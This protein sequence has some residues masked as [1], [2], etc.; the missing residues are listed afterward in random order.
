MEPSNLPPGVTNAM[1]DEHFGSLCDEFEDGLCGDVLCPFDGD[2]DECHADAVADAADHANDSGGERGVSSCFPCGAGGAAQHG[3]IMCRGCEK[4][5]R[6]D[7][8]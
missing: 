3:A 4:D 8:R 7:K 5:D 6:G 1:I 2:P